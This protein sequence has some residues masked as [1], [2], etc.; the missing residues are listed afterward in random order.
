MPTARPM[1]N[2]NAARHRPTTSRPTNGIAGSTSTS[3]PIRTSAVRP[4]ASP[5]SAISARCGVY[6]LSRHGRRFPPPAS[7]SRGASGAACDAVTLTARR[8]RPATPRVSASTTRHSPPNSST[9]PAVSVNGPRLVYC[10]GSVN[11]STRAPAGA[12]CGPVSRPTSPP[13][14]RIASPPR[15]GP[16]AAAAV[17]PF[18]QK[19]PART[20]GSPDMR[21]G[22]TAVPPEKKPMLLKPSPGWA[23]PNAASDLRNRQRAVLRDPV[24]RLQVGPGVAEHDDG[25]GVEQELPQGKPGRHRGRA[26]QAPPAWPGLLPA[27]RGARCLARRGLAGRGRGLACRRLAGLRLAVRRLARSCLAGHGRA[28]HGLARPPAD[29]RQRPGPASWHL[30]QAERGQSNGQ[31]RGDEQHGHRQEHP[32]QQQRQP[33]QQPGH[34]QDGRQHSDPGEPGSAGGRLP[35]RTLRQAAA[36]RRQP[37]LSSPGRPSGAGPP[38]W[39]ADPGSRRREAGG[40]FRLSVRPGVAAGH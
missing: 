31:R 27:R 40:R 6:Q 30:M 10:S 36:D 34:D 4:S 25:L 8:S 23:P 17:V 28:G 18:T 32:G 22:T 2:A 24:A 13:N 1:Q 11:A 9:C 7:A 14:A 26:R 5:P 15:I 12:H 16:S 38:R 20:S 3:P 37:G 33:G 35:G 19:P 39:Q 21:P 29:P